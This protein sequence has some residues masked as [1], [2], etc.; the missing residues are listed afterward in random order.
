MSLIKR[1]E[2][3]LF[4]VL[5]FST[6]DLNSFACTDLKQPLVFA[7]LDPYIEGSVGGALMVTLLISGILLSVVALIR[8]STLFVTLGGLTLIGGLLLYW[9]RT[10][11]PTTFC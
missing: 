6:S 1:I 10:E 8:R 5:Y 7:P 2:L 4:A 3:Y 11:L 9:W